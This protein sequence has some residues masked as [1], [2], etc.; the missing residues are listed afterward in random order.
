MVL[1]IFPGTSI[2]DKRSWT[3]ALIKNKLMADAIKPIRIK[4][5][6]NLKDVENDEVSKSTSTSS[7]ASLK[8]P[9][10]QYEKKRIL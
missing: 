6:R 5:D 9:S 2:L 1:T 7:F 8:G 4:K 10:F 3:S